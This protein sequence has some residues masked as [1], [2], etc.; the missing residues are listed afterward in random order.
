MLCLPK[1]C[2]QIF[3]QSSTKFVQEY[4]HI[5]WKQLLKLIEALDP[6]WLM[7][8]QSCSRCVHKMVHT[9]FEKQLVELIDMRNKAAHNFLLA[10]HQEKLEPLH[11]RDSAQLLDSNAGVLL[12]TVAGRRCAPLDIRHARPKACARRVNRAS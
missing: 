1:L 3:Q 2:C 10:V 5:L 8:W 4:V 6:C 7:F 12:G 11:C 9:F